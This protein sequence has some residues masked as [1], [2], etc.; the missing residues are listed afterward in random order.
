MTRILADTSGLYALLNSR[1]A[2]HDGHGPLGCCP[3]AGSRGRKSPDKNA[4][5]RQIIVT[6]SG[7]AWPNCVARK[8]IG[9]SPLEAKYRLWNRG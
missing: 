7:L 8:A 2:F 3:R 4:A 9:Y 1:D 6:Q 5:V